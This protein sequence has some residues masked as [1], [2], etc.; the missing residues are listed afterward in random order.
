MPT[1]G[2]TTR[3]RSSIPAQSSAS[4]QRASVP[5]HAG[6][7]PLNTTSFLFDDNEDNIMSAGSQGVTSPKAGT[8]LMTP[9]DDTFPTLR[10]DRTSG[11]VS[12]GRFV[13]GSDLTC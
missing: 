1:Q 12:V 3:K 5:V 11:I 8:F 10:S 9:N 2:S 4:Q 13:R 7:G 6:L